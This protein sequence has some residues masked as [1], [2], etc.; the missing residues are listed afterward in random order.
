MSLGMAFHHPKSVS[1]GSMNKQVALKIWAPVALF[2]YNDKHMMHI[3][4]VRNITPSQ[5]KAW[6]LRDFFIGAENL[7]C[8]F[9]GWV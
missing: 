2:A 9:N 7:I 8:G 3:M 6:L 5:V 1:Q 4:L